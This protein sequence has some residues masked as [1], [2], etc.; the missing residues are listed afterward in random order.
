MLP[1]RRIDSFGLW[2]KKN[3]PFWTI[4]QKRLVCW[5][6]GLKTRHG[7]YNGAAF[8]KV[9]KWLPAPTLMTSVQEWVFFKKRSNVLDLGTVC[10]HYCTIIWNLRRSLLYHAGF[11][12]SPERTCSDHCQTRGVQLVADCW[13]PLSPPRWTF[14]LLLLYSWSSCHQRN[15]PQ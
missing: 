14:L 12:S 7:G 11:Y 1:E 10:F 4:S 2:W 13:M 3:Q 6:A 8:R 15:T 5:F 9:N